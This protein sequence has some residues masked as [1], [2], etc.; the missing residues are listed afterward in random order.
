MEVEELD[1]NCTSKDEALGF[2]EDEVSDSNSPFINPEGW[3]LH[4]FILHSDDGTEEDLSSHANK[5]VKNWN[6]DSQW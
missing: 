3:S 6:D 4:N 5:F 1:F 2:I